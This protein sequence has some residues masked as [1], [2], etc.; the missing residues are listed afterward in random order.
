MSACQ[1]ASVLACQRVSVSQL[2]VIG[3]NG[4]AALPVAASGCLVGAL[5]L[6]LLEP[7]YSQSLAHCAGTGMFCG[8]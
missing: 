7:Q 1:R 4:H 6:M 2:G 5:S 3:E 8:L